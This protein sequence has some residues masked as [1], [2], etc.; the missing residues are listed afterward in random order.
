VSAAALAVACVLGVLAV[1]LD[2]CRPAPAPQ[3]RGV[4]VLDVAEGARI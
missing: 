1:S 4:S 3:T 2:V